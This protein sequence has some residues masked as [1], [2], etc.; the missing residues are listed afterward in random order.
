MCFTVALNDGEDF[1]CISVLHEHTQDVKCVR[2]HPHDEVLCIN[3]IAHNKL[4]QT[5]YTERTHIATLHSNVDHVTCTG[6]C[7]FLGPQWDS[8]CNKAHLHTKFTTV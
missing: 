8:V 1:E 7:R 3:S 6:L 5:L 2:W 4:E